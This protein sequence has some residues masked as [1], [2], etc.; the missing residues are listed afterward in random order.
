MFLASS[1]Y[2]IEPNLVSLSKQLLSLLCMAKGLYV[3]YC[4]SYKLMFVDWVLWRI[5]CYRSFHIEIV[6]FLVPY[7]IIEELL[8][9]VLECLHFF[10]KLNI[11]F[12]VF[13][14]I[15]L[16]DGLNVWR[17]YYLIV[18]VFFWGGCRESLSLD[19]NSLYIFGFFK[20]SRMLMVF[21]ARKNS[22]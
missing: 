16:I 20:N 5:N 21:I 13:A 18:V 19:S 7:V 11:K 3:A 17:Y 22:F 15:L 9:M 2:G 10:F 6:F 4:K 12:I 8:F 14:E 1:I